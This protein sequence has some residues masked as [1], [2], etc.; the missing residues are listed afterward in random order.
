MEVFAGVAVLEY[1][2]IVGVQDERTPVEV[3]VRNGRHRGQVGTVEVRG[4]PT[5]Q[6]DDVEP[7]VE[8]DLTGVATDEPRGGVATCDRQ[9]RRGGIDSEVLHRPGESIGERAGAAGHF[10]NA[11]VRDLAE[12]FCPGVVVE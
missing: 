1:G 4:G 10:E 7:T 8:G 12:P 9:H 6:G 5:Q 3:I 2:P 11:P